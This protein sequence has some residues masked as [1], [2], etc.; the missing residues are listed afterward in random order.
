MTPVQIK[1]EAILNRLGGVSYDPKWLNTELAEL[2]EM[3]LLPA[4]QVSEVQ[5]VNLD[6]PCLREMCQGWQDGDCGLKVQRF[7]PQAIIDAFAAE[8]QPDE[9]AADGHEV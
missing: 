1:L 6:R 7:D 4:E 2:A 3:L 8:V 5:C 9:P